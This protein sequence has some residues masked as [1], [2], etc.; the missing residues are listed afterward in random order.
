MTKD[1]ASYLF[2]TDVPGGLASLNF[3]IENHAAEPLVVGLS[4]EPKVPD[5]G[6]IIIAPSVQ[7]L[8]QIAVDPGSHE[9]VGFAFDRPAEQ[10][11]V[12]DFTL[13]ATQQGTEAVLGEIKVRMVT[14]P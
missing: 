6:W 12:L 10:G 4:Y 11:V 3:R 1:E 13:R 9:K 8:E 2:P 14:V 7:A 5:D